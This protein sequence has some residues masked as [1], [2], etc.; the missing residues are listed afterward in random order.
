MATGIRL[1]I[2]DEFA[3]HI[4]APHQFLVDDQSTKLSQDERSALAQHRYLV[5]VYQGIGAPGNEDFIIILLSMPMQNAYTFG[6]LNGT[7][8]VKN[9]EDLHRRAVMA[10]D[11]TLRENALPAIQW[12]SREMPGRMMK[13]TAEPSWANPYLTLEVFRVFVRESRRQESEYEDWPS[14]RR[15]ESLPLSQC[16]GGT[17]RDF[18]CADLRGA[19]G[20]HANQPLRIELAPI[21]QQQHDLATIDAAVQADVDEEESRTNAQDAWVL[22]EVIPDL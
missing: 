2:G 16:H 22:P 1:V 6:A 13:V 9:R 10:L 7:L 3:D 18:W 8:P 4:A 5:M 15:F 14:S 17:V 19:L 20:S 12:R 11:A 21:V